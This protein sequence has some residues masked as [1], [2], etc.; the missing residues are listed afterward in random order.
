MDYPGLAR[1]AGLTVS[2]AATQDNETP[3][4]YVTGEAGGYLWSSC[5]SRARK[6]F[7]ELIENARRSGATSV[8]A[9]IWDSTGTS[10]PGCRRSWPYLVLWPIVLTPI[11]MNTRVEAMAYKSAGAP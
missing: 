10:V 3:V 8:G 11:F 5:E 1:T 6:S 4:G 2:H 7:E 9:V